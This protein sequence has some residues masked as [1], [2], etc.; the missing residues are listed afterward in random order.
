MLSTRTRS[1]LECLCHRCPV[2]VPQTAVS[3]VSPT[4]AHCAK[5][6]F[7]NHSPSVFTF[8]ISVPYLRNLPRN[9]SAKK[10]QVFGGAESVVRTI[11]RA[12]ASPHPHTV[13]GCAGACVRTSPDPQALLA[14]DAGE[15]GLSV[16]GVRQE[17]H[18]AHITQAPRMAPSCSRPVG[19]Q[20]KKP[21]SSLLCS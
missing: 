4:C 11:E 5:T 17:S 15:R 19:L 16:R 2:P 7:T 21:S 12:K 18:A 1:G 9:E 14:D 8:S 13:T 3:T 20:S 6:G 10:F